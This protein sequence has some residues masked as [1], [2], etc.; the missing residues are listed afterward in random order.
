MQGNEFFLKLDG[1]E[2]ES[3]DQKHKGEIEIDSFSLAVANAEAPSAGAG[4]S[5]WQDMRFSGKIDKSYPKLR[6]ACVSGERLKKALLTA[7][8]AG[9]TQQEYLKL[10]MLDVLISSVQLGGSANPVVP[11][12]HFTLTFA[13]IEV[14]QASQKES[15]ILGGKVKIAYDIPKEK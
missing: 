9:K 13:R 3:Q 15:G 4:K 12:M 6:L 2:G 7:R 5:A 11:S 14:E 8:K 1:I 10:T